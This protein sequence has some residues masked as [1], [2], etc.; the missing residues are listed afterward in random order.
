MLEKTR[1]QNDLIEQLTKTHGL[2]GV[3]INN[4]RHSDIAAGDCPAINVSFPSET[5]ESTLTS[6]GSELT[7]VL[8][9][10]IDIHVNCSL[11]NWTGQL[12][13]LCKTVEL[14]LLKQA[15]VS[16]DQADILS[17]TTLIH[18]NM[19]SKLSVASAAVT[20]CLHNGDQ[21]GYRH[22]HAF[23]PK[24]PANDNLNPGKVEFPST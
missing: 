8:K 22:F 18:Q 11:E 7:T 19:G 17:Y 14:A 16:K 3:T 10:K 23:Q 13:A 15:A 9:L 21:V 24:F 2:A 4:S 1:F 5:A 6:R 20:F 12:N